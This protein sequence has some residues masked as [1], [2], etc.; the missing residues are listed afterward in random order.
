LDEIHEQHE[1]AEE[2]EQQE[3]DSREQVVT[4]IQ[5]LNLGD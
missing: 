5:E 3:S 4:K 1:R 2:A